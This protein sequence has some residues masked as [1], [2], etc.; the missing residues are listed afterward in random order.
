MKFKKKQ[1]GKPV[2]CFGSCE[3]HSQ[4]HTSDFHRW[5]CV[6]VYSNANVVAQWRILWSIHSFNLFKL[7]TWWAILSDEVILILKYNEKYSS[8]EN[9]WFC[10]IWAH[11]SSVAPDVLHSELCQDSTAMSKDQLLPCCTRPGGR[12]YLGWTRPQLSKS[13]KKLPQI[14]ML[15][16]HGNIW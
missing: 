9:A 2:A 16:Y 8:G 10:Y 15:I 14:K 12:G 1:S 7:N 13:C 5:C 4:A 3:M 6:L 11:H